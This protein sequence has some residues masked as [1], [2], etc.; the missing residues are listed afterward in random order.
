MGLLVLVGVEKDDTETDTAT[1]AK[2][3]VAL[4]IFEDASGRMNRS[5]REVGGQI[6]AVSQFT[7]LG[8]TRKGRR[9]S[10]DK[11]APP[12]EARHLYALFVAALG[13]AGVEVATGVFREMMDIELTNNGPVTLLLDTRK[14][15]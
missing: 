4:R 2:K 11:A 5:V 15:F 9:P 7:L 8:D 1:L 13:H 6:L 12:D 14:A 3:I 10:F